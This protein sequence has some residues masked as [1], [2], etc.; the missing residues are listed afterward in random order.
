[1]PRDE[2]PVAIKDALAKRVALKCSNPSCQKVTCGPH[3]EVTRSVNVGV[4]S[5]ITAA[6]SGGPRYD[7]SLSQEER[8]SIENAL[9]L[10]QTCAKLIDNDGQRYSVSLLKSWKISAEA[11]ALRALN[12]ELD[13]DFFPQPSNAQHTPIPKIAGLS[14]DEAREKLI[15]AGWQPCL[16]HW[17]HAN[18]FDMQHGNG[19]YFWGKGYCEIM[20]ASGTGLSHCTFGFQD[21]YGTKL[22]IKT[23]GEVIE[24]LDP[25]VHVWS[26]YF[27]P[28]DA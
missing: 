15:N 1:M 4:A 26:W 9:W 12:G 10:C 27:A 6:A 24:G 19:L 28:N 16:N 11:R 23:A 2:F 7:Q 5:H 8:T 18:A 3:S 25:T 21:V 14:Y 20:H 22:I 17:T 13:S